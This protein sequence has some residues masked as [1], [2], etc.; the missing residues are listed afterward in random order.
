MVYIY[1]YRVSM[2]SCRIHINNS[3]TQSDLPVPRA[4]REVQ[5]RI[6]LIEVIVGADD[7]PPGSILELQQQGRIRDLG[8]AA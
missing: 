8:A 3:R 1:V 4:A 6:Q 5:V 7:A 2:K